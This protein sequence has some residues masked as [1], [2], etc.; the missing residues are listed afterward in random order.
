MRE[1]K[2]TDRTRPADQPIGV[3]TTG[4]NTWAVTRDERDD[5]GLTTFTLMAGPGIAG[6]IAPR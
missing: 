2:M 6:V 5:D 3:E 4:P 1:H